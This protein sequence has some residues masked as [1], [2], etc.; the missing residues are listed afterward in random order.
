MRVRACACAWF[1][2]VCVCVLG[3]VFNLST[4]HKSNL[5]CLIEVLSSTYVL[6]F[7]SLSQ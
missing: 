7:S 3:V 2:C 1:V 5:V 4:C 6:D